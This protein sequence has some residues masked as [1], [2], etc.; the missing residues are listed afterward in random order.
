MLRFLHNGLLLTN[1]SIAGN[2][3]EHGREQRLNHEYYKAPLV[4][5][6]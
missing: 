5:G 4:T 3:R 6:L 1:P 2:P